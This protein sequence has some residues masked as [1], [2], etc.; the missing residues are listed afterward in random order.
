[1]NIRDAIIE[2]NKHTHPFR[3]LFCNWIEGKVADFLI[4]DFLIEESLQFIKEEFS[5]GKNP[6]G[7]EAVITNEEYFEEGRYYKPYLEHNYEDEKMNQVYERKIK[8]VEDME[9]T[10][11]RKLEVYRHGKKSIIDNFGNNNLLSNKQSQNI[12]DNIR[13]ETILMIYRHK[14]ERIEKILP[15]IIK[16]KTETYP[17]LEKKKQL[18]FFM[19]TGI[20]NTVKLLKKKALHL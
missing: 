11:K 12:D 3:T 17:Y 1:M 14:I 9:K 18:V 5:G 16:L 8:I 15:L 6:T 4:G 10:I 20:L 2:S 19:M 13:K 7:I